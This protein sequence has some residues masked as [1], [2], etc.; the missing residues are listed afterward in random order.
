MLLWSIALT[1]MLSQLQRAFTS[2]ASGSSTRTGAFTVARD[3]NTELL[4]TT[5]TGGRSPST[6]PGRR[7]QRRGSH[8]PGRPT[9]SSGG[10]HRTPALAARS[11]ALHR[12]ENRRSQTQEGHCCRYR[13]QCFRLWVLAGLCEGLPSCL[14]AVRPGLKAQ[15]GLP[16]G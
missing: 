6:P 15:S 10:R 7:R 3:L 13:S 2:H 11:A 9:W 8:S 4:R 16:S 14:K 1:A 12:T 5:E